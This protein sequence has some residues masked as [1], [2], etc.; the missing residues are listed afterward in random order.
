MGNIASNVVLERIYQVLGNL[1]YN[2][3]IT[4]TYVD[5]DDPWTDFLA[6]AEFEMISTNGLKGYSMDQLIFFRGMILLIKH[7][8]DL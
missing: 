1:V 7:K 6:S 2:V 5:K 3:N 8:V 4:Q